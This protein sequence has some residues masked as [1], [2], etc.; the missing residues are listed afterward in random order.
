MADNNYFDELIMSYL[1]NEL[2]TEEEAFVLDWINSS[3]ANKK[4]FDELRTTWNLVA[5]KQAIKDVNVDS[6]WDQFKQVIGAKELE[7]PNTETKSFLYLVREE[8]QTGTKPT[9]FKLSSSIAVGVSI[10][11]AIVLGWR[12][13]DDSKTAEKRS[14]VTVKKER[15]FIPA[16]FITREVNLTDKSRLLIL[17]DGS[18][19]TL[20]GK[21]LI[22]YSKPFVN[23]KR[24]ITLLGKALFKVAKDKTKPFT[25]FSR[26]LSTSALGTQ[27]TVT[28]FEKAR[29]IIVRLDEGEVVIKSTISALRKLKNDYY[30]LPGQEL[31]YNYRSS[32]AKVR[33]FK[34]NAH[35]TEKNRKSDNNIID[36]LSLI[37]VNDGTWYM[38]NNQPL[39]QVFDQLSGMFNVKIVFSKKDFS[40]L[41]FIGTFNVADSLDNILREI[42]D[43]NNL[44]ITRK[45]DKVIIGK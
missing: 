12:I 13:F 45:E 23:N 20:Y 24:D 42:A 26:N 18:Q 30:L 15:A 27:F 6:E 38:F 16:S 36:D 28:A 8:V 7:V 10:L 1:C 3:E 4:Y 32:I 37:K 14:V 40:K 9:I 22:S 21:S 29:N 2:N 31:T 33:S 25:V 5:A 41:Y 19:V 35:L 39:T 11:L 44:K 17:E 43:I 34:S